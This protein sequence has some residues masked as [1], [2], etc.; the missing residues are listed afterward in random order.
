MYWYDRSPAENPT[1][2]PVRAV[3]FVCGAQSKTRVSP[4]VPAI[5]S[6]LFIVLLSFLPTVAF[7]R[8]AARRE[9]REY[10]VFK[11]RTMEAVKYF[12]ARGGIL[13]PK[14]VDASYQSPAGGPPALSPRRALLGARGGDGARRSL[15]AAGR[16]HL[17]CVAKSP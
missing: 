7:A 10:F 14:L 15:P 13:G 11:N 12:C 8:A 5:V 1:I 4:R 3:A 2:G 16:A 17:P 6:R 9:Y